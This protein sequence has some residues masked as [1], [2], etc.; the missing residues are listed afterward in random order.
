MSKKKPA[1][2][3]PRRPSYQKVE[4]ALN[5]AA[6]DAV[7][8]HRKAGQP[9]VVWKDGQP[10]WVSPNDVDIPRKSRRGKK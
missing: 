1:S 7:E 10:V 6:L 3:G 4:A 5:Q 2:N 8:A 9:L